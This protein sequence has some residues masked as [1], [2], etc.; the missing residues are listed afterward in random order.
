MWPFATGPKLDP[1]QELRLAGLEKR[2]KDI[3]LDWADMYGKFHRLYLR[4]QKAARTDQ[5]RAEDAAD[6]KNGDDPVPDHTPNPMAVRLLNR[7]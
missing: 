1:D 7:R 2:L 6:S 3:E 4:L 5:K